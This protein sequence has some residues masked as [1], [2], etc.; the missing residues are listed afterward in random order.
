MKKYI[1]F[2]TIF[3]RRRFEYICRKDRYDS[4]LRCTSFLEFIFRMHKTL[5]MQRTGLTRQCRIAEQIAALIASS[6]MGLGPDFSAFSFF[7][8]CVTSNCIAL[9]PICGAV[10]T[11]G[12]LWEDCRLW[13]NFGALLKTTGVAGFT[14]DCLAAFI[15]DALVL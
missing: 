3:V 12:T 6:A 5:T 1:N 7:S 15:T 10:A 2:K 11:V 14:V 8:F 13:Y 9:M 4:H